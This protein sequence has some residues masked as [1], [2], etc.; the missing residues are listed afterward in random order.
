MG[1]KVSEWTTVYGFYKG[2]FYM[3]LG[4]RLWGLGVWC[5]SFGFRVRRSLI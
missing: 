2:S 5:N 1:S 3:G 4:H